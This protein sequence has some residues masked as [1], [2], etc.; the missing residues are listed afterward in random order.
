M[1]ESRASREDRMRLRQESIKRHDEWKIEEDQ[2]RHETKLQ[3]DK[4]AI[5]SQMDMEGWDR[6]QLESKK[7]AEKDREEAVLF[8]ELDTIE[9]KSEMLKRGAEKEDVDKIFSKEPIK[10]DESRKQDSDDEDAEPIQ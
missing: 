9:K 4:I 5:E 7:K 10:T 2:I 8:D 1:I 3:M 6:K